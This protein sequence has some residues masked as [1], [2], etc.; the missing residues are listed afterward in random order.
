MKRGFVVSD[1]HLFS[2]R[3]SYERHREAVEAA[4]AC[5]D[6][7][8]LNGDVFEFRWSA[9]PSLADTSREALRWL[10]G[11][12]SRHPRCRF[13]YVLGNHDCATVFLD[14]LAPLADRIGNLEVH[15]WHVRFQDKLFLHGDTIVA[16]PT[17]RA[18]ELFRERFRSDRPRGRLEHAFHD[19]VTLCRAH[20]VVYVL[21][22]RGR[23]CRRV[24]AYVRGL[25]AETSAG[26]R[27]VYFGHTH[28]PLSGYALDGL[29][30]HNSG[31]ALKQL[32]LNLA[33]FRL[34]A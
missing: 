20:M 25:P 6:L 24:A 28:V 7:F 12:C 22:P 16:G 5:C 21:Y 30:F 1:L 9:L 15:P 32:R 23:S 17:P 13:H 31:A 18:V 26:V 3:S 27:H 8:V 34:D 2:R 11:L 33:E 19:L 10:Q 14:G 4:A 29:T